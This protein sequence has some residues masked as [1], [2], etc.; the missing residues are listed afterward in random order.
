M[1]CW[2]LNFIMRFAWFEQYQPFLK[3]SKSR[4]I[5]F[6]IKTIWSIHLF[7]IKCNSK[8]NLNLFKSNEIQIQRRLVHVRLLLDCILSV[9]F[10]Q[11]MF[12]IISQNHLLLF[13]MKQK[14]IAWW[15]QQKVYFLNGFPGEQNGSLL[16]GCYNNCYQI[17]N[18]IRL[19]LRRKWLTPIFTISKF[20]AYHMQHMTCRIS[21]AY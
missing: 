4:W 8:L 14:H 15:Q 12:F 1:G 6:K 16:T 11:K 13:R 10:D 19:F 18:V 9:T 17:K 20:D 21:K 5:C 3:S 7:Y 2:R